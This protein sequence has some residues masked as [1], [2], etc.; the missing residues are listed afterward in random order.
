MPSLRK[1]ATRSGATFVISCC[2]KRHR[3]PEI[4][5][6]QQDPD[7]LVGPAGCRFATLGP[8]APL[9]GVRPERGSGA[10][11]RHMPSASR[12]STARLSP[13]AWI[14]SLLVTLIAVLALPAASL[15]APATRTVT[16]QGYRLVVPAS[17]PVY[18]LA[19]A[20]T[21]C[22][23]FDRH[24][25]YLGRP[26]RA[27][28]LL[29]AGRG[30]HRGDPRAAA[31]RARDPGAARHLRRRDGRHRRRGADRQHGPPGARHRDVES[32]AGGGP[33]RAARRVTGERRDQGGPP[34]PAL[35]GR[36]RRRSDARLRTVARHRSDDARHPGGT[37]RGLHRPGL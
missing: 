23:R 27:A 18:R 26:V 31:G 13:A 1:L 12:R 17:W 14:A 20:P 6:R 16:F 2:C 36:R 33:A 22:V 24:A 35:G 3:V 10:S 30:P 9:S 5:L 11:A 32:P 25:V 21:T 37:G 4:Q 28:E 8:H 29:G 19:T 7:H 15:A 34:A